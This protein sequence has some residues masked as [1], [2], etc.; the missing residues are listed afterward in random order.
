MTPISQSIHSSVADQ[1]ELSFWTKLSYGIGTIG[2]SATGSLLAF[3]FLYFLTDV[4]GISAALAGSILMIGQISDAV[5]DPIIGLLSDRTRSNWGRRYPWIIA[6]AV[7]FGLSFLFMWLIPS[8]N[9]WVLFAYYVAVGIILKTAFT[10]VYLPYVS[11]TPELAK[12][13][14]SR[15]RLNSFRFSFSIGSSI[16]ALALS[17][18]VFH[19]V[20]NVARRYLILG[21]IGCFLCIIPLYICVFGTWKT[22]RTSERQYRAPSKAATLPVREQLVI[23][24]RNKPF[25]IVVGIY[26]CSWLAAQMT[27]VVMQYFV[28][29]WMGLESADFTNFALVVQ[30]TALLML[31]VWSAVSQRIG[32]RAVFFMGTSIWVIAQFGL[33]FLQPGQVLP[34]FLLGFLAGFG[35]STSYLVPWSML[36]DVIELDE[37]KTGQRREGVF[38]AFMVMVQKIGI[39]FGIFLVGQALSLAGYIENLP[40]QPPVEAQ[41]ESALFV[42]RL[43]IGP[44][45]TLILA[46]GLLLAYF[47]P[48]SRDVHA[49]IMMQLHERKQKQQQ[50]LEGDGI[51]SSAATSLHQ[52]EEN[53][54]CAVEDP[55]TLEDRVEERPPNHSDDVREG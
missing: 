24:F 55:T 13:Y 41:P 30:G 46:A 44:I 5:S 2:T 29:S 1:P 42:I 10:A 28:V 19:F 14:N 3:L 18:L 11:L 36:P 37:L 4:A 48:I 39:A 22:V 45:S 9:Q 53:G 47:Y 35:V 23:A 52:V 26:L 31:F 38:Y 50:W 49:T 40:G 12:D 32:K 6:G 43:V 34:M 21:A 20:E 16:L 54:D 8:D 17:S 7:P 25:L 27:A 33:F 51:T 15:T